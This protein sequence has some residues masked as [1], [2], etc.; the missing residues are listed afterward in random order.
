MLRRTH[1]PVDRH[2]NHV[3]AFD[4]LGNKPPPGGNYFAFLLFLPQ[5]AVSCCPVFFFFY[6]H[7]LSSFWK[8]WSQVSSLLPPGSCLQF[9]SRIY[10]VQQSHCSSIWLTHALALSASQFVHKKKSPR[11]YTSM[12]SGG[13]ELTK[14]TYT[15]LED[16]PIR[17]RG[18]RQIHISIW[19][20]ARG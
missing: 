13:F 11:I 2:A 3:T 6:T 4:V 20:G 5:G 18:D 9:L 17:H 1:R 19:R 14:L 8:P 12:H 15:R 7:L 10:R 16:N